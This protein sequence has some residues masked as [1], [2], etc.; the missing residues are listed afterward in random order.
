MALVFPLPR[1]SSF[2]G[3]VLWSE[4]QQIAVVS[5]E[6]IYIYVSTIL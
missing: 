2:T 5:N 1:H 4:D 6:T 3:T